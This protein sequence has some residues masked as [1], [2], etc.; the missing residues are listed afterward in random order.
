MISETKH[1]ISKAIHDLSQ[2]NLNDVLVNALGAKFHEI[3]DLNLQSFFEVPFDQTIASIFK[4]ANEFKKETGT[5]PLC[6]AVGLLQWKIKSKEVHT[7]ILL[8]PLKPKYSKINQSIQFES[9]LDEGF[10]N[11]FLSTYFASEFDITVPSF[12]NSTNLVTDFLEWLNST[13]IP[14]LFQEKQLIG[15]FHHH[16]FQILKDLEGLFNEPIIGNNVE[17][18]LGNEEKSEEV[19]IVL[20]NDNLFPADNDQL[21]VFNQLQHSNTVIQGPP[22]TGKSQVLTNVLGKIIG[23][24]FKA[25]V[26]SEK[27]VALEVLQNKLAQFQLDDFTFITTSE[28]VSH[29]FILSLKKTWERMESP[30]ILSAPVNLKL[31]EQYL[32]NLQIQIDLLNQKELIGGVSF[33][34]FLTQT[35]SIDFSKSEFISDVPTVKNWL[36]DQEIIAEIYRFKLQESLRFLPFESVKND[37][38]LSFDSKLIAWKNELKSLQNCFNIQSKEDVNEAMKQSAI[39]QIIE[40][41]LNKSYFSVLH[42]ESKE[43]K[44]YNS[45]KKKRLSLIKKIEPFQEEI[46]NWKIEPSENETIHLLEALNSSSFFTKRKAK[47][48]LAQL[49]QSSFV[50]P[51]LALTK[52]IENIQL[53]KELSQLQ[54]EFSEIG[55]NSIDFDIPNIDLFIQQMNKKEWEIYTSITP[56]QRKK[57]CEFHSRLHQ[58]YSVLK[59]YFKLKS[60]DLISEV[61]EK[62]E[63]QFEE[64]IRIRSKISSIE[65][66]S[67]RLLEIANSVD[68]YAQIVYKSN[69]VKFESYF[70][71]LAKFSPSEIHSKVNQII[72]AREEESKLF[73]QQI[74]F[75]ISEKFQ[76][77]HHLLRTPSQKLSSDEKEK[78]QRLKKGKSIL[79]KEFSKSKSHP[80]IRELLESDA[81][82]WIHLL[83]PIWLSNPVQ[84]ARCFPL[85]KD[86]FDFVIF[87]EATQI[88]L[89]NALGS[90]H[91]GKRIIVAGDEQQ[92]SPSSY[93]QSTS[94]TVDLLHQAGYYWKNIFLKHHYRSEHTALIEF[95]NRHFYGNSLIAYPSINSTKYPIQ[96]HYCEN[97]LFD[98]R[99]NIEEAIMVA[100]LLE[101]KLELNQSIGVV[102]F[103]E[104]QLNCIFHQLS[105]SIQLKIAERIDQGTLFFKSLENV[106]GE[107]CDALLISFGYGKNS[108]GEFHMRFGP[109][110]QKTGSKRLN[111]LLT[112]AKKSID[113]VSSVLSKDFKISENESV[114]LLRL[115][116]M[117]IEENK[118]SNENSIQFPF[119]LMPI[120][121][122]KSST[123]TI[124]FLSIYSKI[125]EANELVTFQNAL[126]NRGWKLV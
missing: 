48:R 111:V 86:F 116:L 122:E 83:K 6:L 15:N 113:F 58:F 109:L 61:I 25:L 22:G 106:Q 53:N 34:E 44:K 124:Q 23:A 65:N 39:C 18:I 79:V 114:N 13:S 126:Q 68:E 90:L 80:S 100:K 71:E 38:F 75:Y 4:K 21:N 76:E 19:E 42:P 67:F 81:A 125:Q 110:N 105:P 121:I 29:D 54:I 46:K 98:E 31:S 78:K 119:D 52:W 10:M 1:I 35:S 84:V 32:Q 64:L 28:T 41:E 62:I 104:T 27:R 2:L 14:F 82:I 115:F 95:S 88:P 56:E 11:P 40:N 47:K 17:Q 108:D 60:T 74:D 101:E 87:D 92:M 99:E 37:T 9:S 89:A 12:C 49:T 3:D 85:E 73:S 94:E 112:R 70:P 43:Q 66:S 103:S 97:G 16:R 120:R 8:I 123:Y 72:L 96:L 93:F 57:L 102:A 55:V 33:D 30:S 5:N 51:V 7:P 117:Q 118:L 36:N 107:E 69:W 24:N 91:R 26:V 63:V 50:N 45:L 20:T 59:T 77:F